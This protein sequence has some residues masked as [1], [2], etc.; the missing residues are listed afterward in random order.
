MTE[1]L[2]CYANT[3]CRVLK[4][5]PAEIALGRC[6]KD[7]YP[8][9]VSSLLPS[10]ENLLSVPVKDKFQEKIRKDAGLRWSEHSKVLQPLQLGVWVQLQNLK[11]SHPL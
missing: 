3:K 2:L 10:P 1:A 7:F 5:F 6:L 4:K 8:R 9:Q 11:G